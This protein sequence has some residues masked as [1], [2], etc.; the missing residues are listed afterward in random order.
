MGREKVM[1]ARRE[2]VVSKVESMT[3]ICRK[4]VFISS[5]GD[6]SIQIV[7]KFPE[8]LSIDTIGIR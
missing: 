8:K 7:T 6:C 1:A 3:R 5:D 4:D 2:N